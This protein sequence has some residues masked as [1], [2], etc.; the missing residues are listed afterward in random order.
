MNYLALPQSLVAML[1]LADRVATATTA[2]ADRVIAVWA[3]FTQ[4]QAIATYRWLAAM[5]LA[6]VELILLTAILVYARTAQ[7]FSTKV[8]V[9]PELQAEFFETL[10]LAFEAADQEADDDQET[11]DETVD[12]LPTLKELFDQA[13]KIGKRYE[14][15]TMSVPVQTLV[16]PVDRLTRS[17]ELH[18]MTLK[19]LAPL[20]QDLG[21]RTNKVRKADIISSILDAEGYS[22]SGAFTQATTEEE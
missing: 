9:N 15:Q 2:A 18:A 8:K 1:N 19:A 3:F 17:T 14:S 4:P 22:K 5:T 21:L 6:L 11:D 7:R 13:D 12:D 10:N 20:A 16:I